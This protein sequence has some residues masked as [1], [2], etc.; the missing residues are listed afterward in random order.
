VI[1]PQDDKFKF[2]S[3]ER[4]HKDSGID[5]ALEHLDKS[6]C[7]KFVRLPIEAGSSLIPEQPDMS[8]CTIHFRSLNDSGRFDMP[9]QPDKPRYLSDPS[10]PIESGRV[11][12]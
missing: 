7:C 2:R 1:Q 11:E 5:L 3:R 10:L 9:E 4:L 12:M 8:R 6:R